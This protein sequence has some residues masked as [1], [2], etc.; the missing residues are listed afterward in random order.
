MDSDISQRSN[1]N[2]RP[3]F[4]FGLAPSAAPPQPARAKTPGGAGPR[5]TRS[6]SP[7]QRS[8]QSKRPV[9]CEQLLLVFP[10]V[11]APKRA[12]YGGSNP[13]AAPCAVVRP[14]KD[15]SRIVRDL[16]SWLPEI[17]NVSTILQNGKLACIRGA[18]RSLN[19]FGEFS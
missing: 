11:A 15:C 8:N 12:P 9:N 7:Q 16:R 3:G 1:C 13:P 2:A 10:L 6:S 18:L 17:T 14:G 19:C 4:G 5:S